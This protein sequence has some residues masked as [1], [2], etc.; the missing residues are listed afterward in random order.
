M[1]GFL[2]NIHSWN[3]PGTVPGNV[4][5]NNRN[6]SWELFPGNSS[7]E[8][9]WKVPGNSG[10]CSWE[11]LF[12]EQFPVSWEISGKLF[13]GTKQ[14]HFPGTFQEL[15]RNIPGKL[16]IIFPTSRDF[17]GIFPFFLG[18]TVP[19]KVGRKVGNVSQEGS[20]E[21]SQEC[22]RNSISTLEMYFP[23]TFLGIIIPS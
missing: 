1:E 22:S 4:P 13:P 17:P 10:K 14:E 21:C 23:G 3:V 11:K 5:G 6:I 15:S 19:D 18:K 2:E 16:G 9:S 20:W 7:W 12:L 8:C